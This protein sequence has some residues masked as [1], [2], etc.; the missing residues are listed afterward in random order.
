MQFMILVAAQVLG[1]FLTAIGLPGLWLQV[2]SLGIFAWLG[3]FVT[4][5][6]ISVGVV[7]VLA[8]LAEVAEF[9][10]GGRYA[11]KYGGGSRAAMG[12]IIGGIVGA[13][14]GFPLP[15]LGSVFGA[16]FGAFLG[17]FLLELTTGRGASPALR[18]G[19]GAFL[20]RVVATAMKAGVGV[21]ILVLTVIVAVR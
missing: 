17:A 5:S 18:A 12:A 6:A 21:V 3:G 11:K 2:V 19:W 8:L 15:L 7:V 10:L 1:L 9:L 20:G 13:L 14:V 16:M 4:V